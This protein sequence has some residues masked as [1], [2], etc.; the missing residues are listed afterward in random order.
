MRQFGKL[1]RAIE[2]AAGERGIGPDLRAL[3]RRL[4]WGSLHYLR[5]VYCL[6]SKRRVD[7]RLLL[8]NLDC[9]CLACERDLPEMREV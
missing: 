2:S 5:C 8:D 1:A 7:T 4:K 3:L 9:I 6:K